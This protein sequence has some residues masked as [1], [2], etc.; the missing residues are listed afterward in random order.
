MECESRSTRSDPNTAEAHGSR[1]RRGGSAA[2]WWIIVTVSGTVSLLATRVANPLTVDDVLTAALLF[3]VVPAVAVLVLSM[4][5]RLLG[6]ALAVLFPFGWLLVASDPADSIFLWLVPVIGAALVTAVAAKQNR[7]HAGLGMAAAS[8]FLMVVVF[9]TPLPSTAPVTPTTLLV[10]IDGATWDRIDPLVESGKLPNLE[11]LMEGGQRARLR[12]LPSLYSP[13]IWS[14]MAT[15]CLPEVHGIWDFGNTQSDFKVGRLWDRMRLDGRSS[16][17]CGWY[18]TWPPQT[19][20][21]A[22]DFI[23]PSTLAPDSST[24]PPEYA[25]YWQL[26]AREHPMRSGTIPYTV[27]ALRAFKHGARLSTLREGL[28]EVV[29]RRFAAREFLDQAWRDRCISANLQG[30]IFCELIRTRR[31]EFAAILMNQVDKVSH[32]YWKFLEPEGFPDVTDEDRERFSEAIDFLYEAV[33]TNLGKILALVPEDANIVI[34]S[35]HGFRAARRKTAGQFCRIRTENLI[36]A[37][38]YTETVFGTNVDRKV[39]LRPTSDSFSEREAT[40][41]RL[42]SI[43]RGAHLSSDAR[44]FFKLQREGDSIRLEIADRDAIAEQALLVLDNCDYAVEELIRVRE[45]ARFSGEHHPDGVFLL[46]GPAAPSAVR[47]DSLNVVDV[48]PT[49]AALLN[50]PFST[51]WT[52]SPA[53]QGLSTDS[54]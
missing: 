48:A 14:T 52:G 54:V 38:G 22:N 9:F 16:G 33:D 37:L 46:A 36:A 10:G 26:W 2:F 42:T 1:H 21:G 13:Q 32:L 5:H 12:S 19:G 28:T 8:A 7:G 44:P 23:I 15:G 47:S 20:L 25:F 11:R 50:L 43:L 31:P 53:V 41:E 51:D 4:F 27:A 17:V 45:E 3:F 34:V 24:F 30:D 18:F 29:T 39:Y 49:I 35:D 40:L 6:I